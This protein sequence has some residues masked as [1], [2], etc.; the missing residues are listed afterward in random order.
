MDQPR[1]NT[2]CLGGDGDRVGALRCQP[3]DVIGGGWGARQVS[4]PPLP[5]VLILH[6]QPCPS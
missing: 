6:S 2:M 1:H 5:A 4:T 3:R